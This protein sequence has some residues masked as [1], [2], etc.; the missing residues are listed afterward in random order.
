[1]IVSH[2]IGLYPFHN[3]QTVVKV[4]STLQ[5]YKEEVTGYPWILIVSVAIGFS[6]FSFKINK[7]CTFIN[8]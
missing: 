4:H 6:I 2:E 7:I 5:Y 8:Q 3:I 1:M